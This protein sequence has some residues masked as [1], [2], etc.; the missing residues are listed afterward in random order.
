MPQFSM[1]D[2]QVFIPTYNRPVMLRATLESV[3]GQSVGVPHIT[4]LDNGMF[5]S[6][7]ET[8]DLFSNF[9]VNYYDSTS[10]GRFGNFLLAQRLLSRK[11]VLLLHDDD[12]IHPDYLQFVLNAINAHSEVTL[13]TCDVI[14]WQV[15]TAKKSIPN[16]HNRGHVFTQQEFA[17][18]IYNS[19]RP[20]FSF[21]VYAVESFKKINLSS[22]FDIYGKWGDTPL[23]IEAV[24]NGKAVM[25][26]DTCGW[27]GVHPGRDSGD[28]ATLPP[29]FSWINLEK[30]FC[31]HMGDDPHTFSGLSFCIMNFRH[32]KSGFKR[33][34]KKTM[35]YSEYM[36]TAKKVKALTWCSSLFRL[37]SNHLTQ[38]V[39]LFFTHK[40]YKWTEKHLFENNYHSIS[41][42]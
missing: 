12:Q 33:R 9:N 20:S 21:A 32:L 17:T 10:L 13:V 7:K 24:G 34:I 38:K 31:E 25:F 30:Q 18:F 3:I 15:G 27:V 2:I 35:S 26:M 11:Y 16:L 39:F 36:Q 40:Y 19:E 6:T 4:V 41:S 1:D 22:N 14:E 8:V 37:F 29:Y 42:K 28:P 5:P 23:M